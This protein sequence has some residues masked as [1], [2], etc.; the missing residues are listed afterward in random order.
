M[1]QTPKHERAP[2]IAPRKRFVP[3]KVERHEKLPEIT[4]FSFPP[5]DR[6]QADNA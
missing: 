1:D 6:T 3:P 5:D 4:G 2:R